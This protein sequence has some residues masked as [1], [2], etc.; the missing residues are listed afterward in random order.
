MNLPSPVIRSSLIV[1]FT[2]MPTVWLLFSSLYEM[3]NP[4]VELFW[5][6]SAH[7]HV[8]LTLVDVVDSPLMFF[9]GFPGTKNIRIIQFKSL[10]IQISSILRVRVQ[11]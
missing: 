2:A 1:L 6:Q 8:T 3:R 5:W 9:G 7:S 4:I 11:Y 10:L